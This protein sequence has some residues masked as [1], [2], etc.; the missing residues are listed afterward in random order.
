MTRRH[1]GGPSCQ[2]AGALAQCGVLRS[3][4]HSRARCPRVWLRVMVHATLHGSPTRPARLQS[5]FHTNET[6]LRPQHSRS[7]SVTEPAPLLFSRISSSTF[8]TRVPP[9]PCSLRTHRIPFRIAVLSPLVVEFSRGLGSPRIAVSK[10]AAN[11]LFSVREIDLEVEDRRKTS[12]HSHPVAGFA[13]HLWVF[14]CV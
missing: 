7:G 10:F 11:T 12:Y 13:A 2:A 8:L 9:L 1:Y 6:I 4:V 3:S 14:H 5:L